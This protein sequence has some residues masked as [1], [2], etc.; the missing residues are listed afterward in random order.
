MKA[1]PKLIIQFEAGYIDLSEQLRGELELKIDKLYEQNRF[2]PYV[3]KRVYRVDNPAQGDLLCKY[4]LSKAPKDYVV[5]GKLLQGIKTWFNMY[6][7][8]RLSVINKFKTY[9][10]NFMPVNSNEK[11]VVNI[12]FCRFLIS[13]LLVILAESRWTDLVPRTSDGQKML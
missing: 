7:H 10:Q 6:Y 8:D 5:S 4:L 1:Y 3:N 13:D 11:P 2:N 9:C 12:V